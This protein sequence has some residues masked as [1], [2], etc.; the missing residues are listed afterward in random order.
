[1]LDPLALDSSKSFYKSSFNSVIIM[2]LNYLALITW[3]IVSIVFLI[4]IRVLL[5]YINEMYVTPR[6]ERY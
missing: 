3:L 5:F 2:V 1:M 6:E 4:I